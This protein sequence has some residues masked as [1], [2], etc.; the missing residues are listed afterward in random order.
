MALDGEPTSVAV[1]G[2]RAYV[3]VNTSESYTQPSGQLMAFDTTTG[4][5]LASCDLGGQPDSVASE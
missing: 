2:R 5:E 1:V 3:G 4:K